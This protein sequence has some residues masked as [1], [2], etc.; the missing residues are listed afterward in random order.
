MKIYIFPKTK[1]K[2]GFNITKTKDGGY[3]FELDGFKMTFYRKLL[4]SKIQ[5]I[6]FYKNYK[7]T[8]L[9]E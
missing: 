9:I 5:A 8:T 3:M 2:F 6:N 7:L 1:E 4:E